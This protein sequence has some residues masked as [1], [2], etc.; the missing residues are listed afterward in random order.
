MKKYDVAI[1]GAGPGGMAA[2]L[3]AA[4]ANLTVAMIDRGVYGGQMNNTAEV[5]NYPGFPSI[6]GPELGEKMYLLS[7]VLTLFMGMF[8]G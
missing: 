1:I 5:E 8:K 3:Y 6:L 2:A 4:R 7:K